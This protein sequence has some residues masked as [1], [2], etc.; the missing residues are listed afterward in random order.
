MSFPLANWRTCRRMD[1]FFGINKCWTCF[2]RLK[3]SSNLLLT[4]RDVVTANNNHRSA[5][6]PYQR[7]Y[8][9]GGLSGPPSTRLSIR[10]CARTS[11]V[12]AIVSR[13]RIECIVKNTLSGG[14]IYIHPARKILCGSLSDGYRFAGKTLLEKP[15]ATGLA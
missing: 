13:G 5:R 2:D 6:S 10:Q 9:R 1:S 7:Q 11:W 4:K 8:N 14:C 15:N 3:S 12:S